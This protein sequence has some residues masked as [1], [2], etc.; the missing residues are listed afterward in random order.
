M[1]APSPGAAG[2]SAPAAW[3]PALCLVVVGGLLGVTASVVKLALVGGWQPIAFLFWTCL[4]GGVLLLAAALAAGR[5]PGLGGAHLAYYL[6]AG[7]LSFAVPNALGFLAIPHVGA[8]FVALCLA[9]PPLITYGLALVL[10]MDRL[11]WLKVLGLVL[12]LGG[13]GILAV[14]KGSSDTAPLG[15]V[16][17]A[18]ASPV[19]IATGN[20]YRSRFWP[21]GASPLALAPGMLLGAAVVLGV[22]ATAAGV[23]L[24]PLMPATTAFWLAPLQAAIFALTYG[25]YFLLQHLS[26]PVYLSQIGWVGACLGAAA[27][28]VLTG[29]PVPPAL[30]FA[31]P[32]VIAGILLTSR[33]GR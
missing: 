13:A 1:T 15:W 18:L 11:V 12:G 28:V 33:G 2:A 7:I 25:F 23:P 27:A 17:A 22:G 5:R 14:A 29:E 21:A 6:I 3:L 20:I 8:G 30:A 31:A 16:L 26:G 4:G 10:R 24:A 9:F 32:V 19:I